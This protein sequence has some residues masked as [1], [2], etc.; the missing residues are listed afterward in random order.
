MTVGDYVCHVNNG[1]LEYANPDAYSLFPGQPTGHVFLNFFFL[2]AVASVSVGW[3]AFRNTPE[4]PRFISVLISSAVFFSLYY[5]SGYLKDSPMTVFSISMVVWAIQA[6][7]FQSRLPGIIWY[8]VVIGIWGPVW[9]GWFSEGGFFIY[10]DQDAYFVPVWL[11]A[12]YFNGAI[13]I[14]TAVAVLDRWR[15]EGIPLPRSSGGAT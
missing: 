3:L 6:H 9:E 10:Y 1:V 15:V 8:S 14:A 11:S 13:A 7:I 2:I 5:L 4:P 12:L